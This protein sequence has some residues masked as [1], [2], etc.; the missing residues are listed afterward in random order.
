[1]LLNIAVTR[2]KSLP[3]KGQNKVSHSCDNTSLFLTFSGGCGIVGSEPLASMVT[4]YSLRNG[5]TSFFVEKLKFEYSNPYTH[6]I[7]YSH[8]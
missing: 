7:M 2:E 3:N 5:G 1:M 8:T 4:I 6:L